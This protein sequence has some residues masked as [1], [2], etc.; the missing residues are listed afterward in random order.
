M[1]KET[2]EAYLAGIIDA[3]G[4]IM[5]YSNR[6]HYDT[7]IDICQAKRDNLEKL[8]DIWGGRIQKGTRGEYHLI[9]NRKQDVVYI[10]ESVLHFLKFKVD[11][12]GIILLYLDKVAKGS[13]FPIDKEYGKTLF[14]QMQLLRKESYAS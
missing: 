1:P 12:A 10:L 5:L 3:D 6:K 4:S 8:Q 13:G 2:E 14:N 9:W 11:Q 7:R